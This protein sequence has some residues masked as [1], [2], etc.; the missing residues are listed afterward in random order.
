MASCSVRF[1]ALTAAAFPNPAT[2]DALRAQQNVRHLLAALW[3]ELSVDER[4]SEGA[5]FAGPRCVTP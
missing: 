2:V 5:D 1:S 4:P 3:V